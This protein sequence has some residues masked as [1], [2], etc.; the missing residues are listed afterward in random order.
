MERASV[1]RPAAF[2]A[3]MFAAAVGVG[4]MV[5]GSFAPW[6]RVPGYRH[7]YGR[8]GGETDV[9]W[10]TGTEAPGMVPLVGDGMVVLALGGLA[11]ALVLWR[12]LYPPRSSGFLLLAVFTMLALGAFVCSVNLL[13]VGNIPRSDS[14]LFF[15]GSVEPGWGL[16]VVCAGAWLGLLA[17]G[18]Q[19]WRDEL[20]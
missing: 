10:I 7:I 12:L 19:L 18:Y 11:G 6:A 2:P 4:M 17:S 5:T 13:N 1:T 16:F 20:R 15:E 8:V 3:A 9:L 14:R